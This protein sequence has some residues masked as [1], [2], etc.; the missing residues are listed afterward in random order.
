MKHYYKDA[1]ICYHMANQ[2]CITLDKVP[3]IGHF[4][5]GTEDVYI[6]TGFNK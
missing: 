6:A 3:Y 5:P 1:E 2:D 4:T